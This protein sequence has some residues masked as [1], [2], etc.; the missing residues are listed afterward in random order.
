MYY[1]KYRS[2]RACRVHAATVGRTDTMDYLAIYSSI[3][4]KNGGPRTLGPHT[5]RR[6]GPQYPHRIALAGRGI[7]WCKS[8]SKCIVQSLYPA[9]MQT[10]NFQ[11]RVHMHTSTPK[12]LIGS[13][14]ISLSRCCLPNDE[15]PGPEIFFPWTTTVCHVS[16]NLWW[17]AG[18]SFTIYQSVVFVWFCN[19]GFGTTTS[20]QPDPK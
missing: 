17:R 15:G 3:A 6:S 5:A 14:V 18:C 16:Q 12:F 13:I 19:G 1:T 10:A 20:C 2:Q 11:T 9:V 7:C 8:M 4:L